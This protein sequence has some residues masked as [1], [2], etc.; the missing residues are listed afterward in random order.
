M[1]FKYNYIGDV[2]SIRSYF[3]D[4]EFQIIYLPNQIDIINYQ[5]IDSFDDEKIRIRYKEGVLVIGGKNLSI[6]KLLED[7]VLIGGKIEKIEFR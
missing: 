7:E 1:L 3:I 2:M 4:E 6:N 5:E